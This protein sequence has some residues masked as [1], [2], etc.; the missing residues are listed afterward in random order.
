MVSSDNDIKKMVARVELMVRIRNLKDLLQQM[1]RMEEYELCGQLREI[2]KRREEELMKL[3][4]NTNNS[5]N[6]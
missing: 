6:E 3:D 1:I 5:E 2:I 4:M